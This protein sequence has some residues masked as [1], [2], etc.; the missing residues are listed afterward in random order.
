MFSE[1]GMLRVRKENPLLEP[2]RVFKDY[3]VHRQL[4]FEERLE[5]LDSLSLKFWLTK[6]VRDVANKTGGRYTP[7]SL[8]EI[9][10]GLKRHL[11]MD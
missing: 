1:I 6:F 9:F 5:D 2:G 7:R 8:Y 11:T 4:S 10:C 3:D